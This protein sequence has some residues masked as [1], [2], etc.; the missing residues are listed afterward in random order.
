[1]KKLIIILMVFMQHI[2]VVLA[3]DPQVAGSKK[4]DQLMKEKIMILKNGALLVRLQTKEN[5]I[6]ALREG[7]NAEQANQVEARQQA[8]NKEVVAAFKSEFTFCPVYFFPS[9]YSENILSGDVNAVVF[10][11]D[12]LQPDA[13]IKFSQKDFLTAEFGPIEPDT[14]S[15]YEDT[16]YDRSGSNLEK[17]KGYY[18]GANMGF[19]ALKIMNKN[20][21]QLK[22]PFPYYVRTYDSLPVERKL[23]KAVKKMNSELND[24]YLKSKGK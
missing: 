1:M 12:S 8:F 13:S 10:V 3:Q 6:N 9:K 21:I 15:Y 11:N 16:H 24:F 5:S 18:G 4:I 17:D 19:E 23:S 7:G 20:F 22:K 2:S 14:A